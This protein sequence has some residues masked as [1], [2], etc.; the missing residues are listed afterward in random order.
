MTPHSIASGPIPYA[1]VGLDRAGDRRG[2]PAW[3]ATQAADPR[4]VVRPMWNDECLVADG[5]PVILPVTDAG[6]LVLLGLAG[7]VPV[8]AVD[9]SDLDRADALAGTGADG[10]ADIRT[11]FTGLPADE[12][13]TLAFARGLL[14]WHRFQ[15]Y[16]GRCGFSAEPRNGGQF[17]VCTNPDCCPPEGKPFEQTTTCV[18]AAAVYAGRVALPD[19]EAVAASIAPVSG[20]A[21][22]AMTVWCAGACPAG[23]SSTT[24]PRG[25]TLASPQSITWT[26]PKLPTI[27]F[28]G[29]MSR[30]ITP[31]ACA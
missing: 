20:P 22:A 10:T 16:C 7:E 12:A 19:R 11:L 30:W 2:D 29:L 27:T 3:V 26:S 14:R 1:G 5:V 6:G 13:A 31:R 4:A 8:F 28:D 9:L 23:A 24:P 21:R 18:G 17:R 15:R 25:N